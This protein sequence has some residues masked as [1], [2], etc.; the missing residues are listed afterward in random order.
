MNF[1]R[2]WFVVFVG[3]HHKL[4]TYF[5]CGHYFQYGSKAYVLHVST[6]GLNWTTTYDACVADNGTMLLPDAPE[7]QQAVSEFYK[8]YADVLV[9]E[10]IWINFPCDNNA[11][12][13]HKAQSPEFWSKFVVI[14]SGQLRSTAVLYTID[15]T[16]WFSTMNPAYNKFICQYTGRCSSL[17]VYCVNHGACLRDTSTTNASCHC[18]AG[19]T[20]DDCNTDID[21]CAPSKCPAELACRDQVNGFICYCP[22][23]APCDVTTALIAAPTAAAAAEGDDD[24]GLTTTQLA[25]I[26]GVAGMVLLLAAF[27]AYFSHRKKKRRMREAAYPMQ[28]PSNFSGGSAMSM[29][30]MSMDQGGSIASIASQ[31]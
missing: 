13:Q 31:Y 6:K 19:Y 9:Q 8:L 25:I 21:D 1:V 27:A 20:G 3:F 28:Q 26:G 12:T 2:L 14:G 11:C 22:A 5:A 4:T 16:W 24:G 7:E 18:D 15:A 29:G 23:G 10:W 30:A 17:A